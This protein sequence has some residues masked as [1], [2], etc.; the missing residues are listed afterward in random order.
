MFV[1]EENL[2]HASFYPRWNVVVRDELV[3][4]K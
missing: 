1:K 3:F 2:A 4:L